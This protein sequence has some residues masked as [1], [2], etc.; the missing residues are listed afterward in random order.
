MSDRDFNDGVHDDEDRFT[1]L[2]LRYLDGANSPQE[3]AALAAELSGDAERR[4]QF[5]AICER[6]TLL[7]EALVIDGASRLSETPMAAL[8]DPPPC[9]ASSPSLGFLGG[10]GFSGGVLPGVPGLQVLL[11][12]AL[13]LAGVAAI[14]VRGWVTGGPRQTVRDVADANSDRHR[15]APVVIGPSG[16]SPRASLPPVAARLVAAECQWVDPQLALGKG[17]LL[18]AGQKL[19]LASGRVEIVFQ[20]GAEV[21]LHGPAIFE[22]QSANSSF[23]TIGR[24]S[25]RAA[26]PE[27]HGFTVHSRTAATVDLGTEFNVVASDDGHS[28]IGV[29]A[30]AVEV[31]LTNGQQRRRLGVG[32]SIEVEPGTPS[33]IARIEPGAG[34]PAFKFPTIEPPSRNDYADVSQGHAHIRVLRGR[35]MDG[36]CGSAPVEVLLDGKGQSSGSAPRESFFF[37]RGSSGLILLDL[38]KS[39]PVKKVNTYSWHDCDFVL[40]HTRATQKY[41]LYGSSRATPPETEGNLAGAGWTLIAQVNTDEFFG[42]PQGADRPA[43]QAVSIMATDSGSIGKYRYLL[44]DVRPTNNLAT[45]YGEFDVFRADTD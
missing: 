31:Q 10:L 40:D 36:S 9:D 44:W 4:R 25:A 23:L 3:D 35:P 27:A 28:Q 2:V 19:E 11:F 5:V 34:T 26:T 17:A 33:V 7:R 30:G 1:F 29:V 18:V 15:S 22:I 6:A 12:A 20:S 14:G 45:F 41:Y 42:F 32:E 39:I 37:E 24:L 16:P 21:K 43:Q 8:P 13:L 38:G